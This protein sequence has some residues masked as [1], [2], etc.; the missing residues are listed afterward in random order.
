MAFS[1]SGCHITVSSILQVNKLDLHGRI[2][3]AWDIY[4]SLGSLTLKFKLS[5][6]SWT[7]GDI[8]HHIERRLINT[9][10]VNTRHPAIHI[11]ILLNE[12]TRVSFRTS[13]NSLPF[14]PLLKLRSVY[15]LIYRDRPRGFLLAKQISKVTFIASIGIQ[16]VVYMRSLGPLHTLA[17]SRV[18]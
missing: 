18:Q 15:K 5:Q 8:Y 13:S 4:V 9:N 10:Q 6:P 3:A 12:G 11:M 7:T 17:K 16:R 1:S 14:V 2:T